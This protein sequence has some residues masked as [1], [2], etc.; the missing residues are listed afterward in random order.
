MVGSTVR[1][2]QDNKKTAKEAHKNLLVETNALMIHSDG[3]EIN[4][5]TGAAAVSPHRTIK[6]F[7]GS[8]T[9]FT[10]YSVELYGI[11]LAAILAS[12]PGHG[13]DKVIICIDNQAAITG[14]R[15]SGQQLQSAFGQVFI[16]KLCSKGVEVELQWVPAHIGI[17]GNAMADI[18]AKQATGRRQKKNRRGKLVEYDS[19]HTAKPAALAHPLRSAQKTTLAKNAL[20]ALEGGRKGKSNFATHTGESGSEATCRAI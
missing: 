16:E 8:S 1:R 18:A 7:L 19:K 14:N 13:K 20:K 11:I 3:S 17:D 5:K 6:P 9:N 4:L 10:V 2:R 15:E 12:I